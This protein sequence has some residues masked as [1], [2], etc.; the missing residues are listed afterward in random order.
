MQHIAFKSYVSFNEGKRQLLE[1]VEVQKADLTNYLKLERLFMIKKMLLEYGAHYFKVFGALVE[2][3]ENL[4][5]ISFCFPYI[6]SVSL[7]EILPEECSITLDEIFIN[8]IWMMLCHLRSNGFDG[9]IA[10]L[11]SGKRLRLF[12]DNLFLGIDGR[13]YLKDLNLIC[14][15]N[16]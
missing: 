11:I 6:P 1:S 16:R 2:I 13:L 7:R 12:L 4:T 5:T 8:K 14:E 15:A 3:K 10:E 9:F